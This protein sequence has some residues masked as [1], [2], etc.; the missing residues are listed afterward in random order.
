MNKDDIKQVFIDND[1]QYVINDRDFKTAAKLLA[2]DEVVLDGVSG[3]C[4]DY[5]GVLLL[6]NTRVLWVSKILFLGTKVEDMPL[7]KISSIEYEA[8]I[9]F[10]EIKI[11]VSH[12]DVKVTQVTKDDI[13]SFVVAVRK[14]MES[15]HTGG[16]TSNDNNGGKLN[17]SD[18]LARL[19]SL[20]SSGVLDETEFKAAKAKLLG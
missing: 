12:N 9:M 6:T 11:H 5:V 18:E 3:C 15:L 20:Y 14:Q 8:G 16:T 19:A 1:R 17:L 13:Q 10:G 7:A 4:G 2:D